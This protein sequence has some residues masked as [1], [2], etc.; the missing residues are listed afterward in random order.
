[1]YRGDGYKGVC[2]TDCHWKGEYAKKQ[3]K[4]VEVKRVG[5]S[6]PIPR[7]D[8][9]KKANERLLK[10]RKEAHTPK[11]RRRIG[12]L[13]NSNHARHSAW[14]GRQYMTVRG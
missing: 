7:E 10:G 9:I 6:K 14:S 5:C 11:E 12:A 2:T 13:L 8:P 1:M 3:G 4:I